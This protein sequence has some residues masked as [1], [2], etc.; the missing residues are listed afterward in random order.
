MKSRPLI[1]RIDN[2]INISNTSSLTSSN[3]PDLFS[4]GVV[5]FQN[6]DYWTGEFF[7]GLLIIRM[8]YGV[9]YKLFKLKLWLFVSEW[10]W[11][12]HI[13]ERFIKY[14]KGRGVSAF[15][16]ISADYQ[17][18][19]NLEVSKPLKGDKT[20]IHER[21]LKYGQNSSDEHCVLASKIADVSC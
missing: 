10:M 21:Y 19:L 5:F 16:T 8:K 20:Q 11:S 4:A 3:T 6:N 12:V 1:K 13:G 2:C 18:G 15:T 14:W 9:Q 17:Y 7:K